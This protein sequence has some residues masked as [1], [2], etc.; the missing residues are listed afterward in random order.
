MSLDEKIEV[1]G[2]AKTGPETDTAAETESEEFS[3]WTGRARRWVLKVL[4]P[5]KLLPES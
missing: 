1:A 2:R 4:P 3:T 5:E